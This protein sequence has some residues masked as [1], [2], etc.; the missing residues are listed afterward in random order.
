MLRQ[1]AETKIIELFRSRNR[2]RQ[3]SQLVAASQRRIHHDLFAHVL[4]REAIATSGSGIFRLWRDRR[5]VFYRTDRP[6][7]ALQ[8]GMAQGIVDLRM[9]R[10]QY[11]GAFR[12][13]D[14]GL[15]ARNLR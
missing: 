15:F 10:E 7:A 3:I 11:Y 1:Y 14:S 13:Q 2:Q 4:Q 5:H 9:L 6:G 8:N 12:T